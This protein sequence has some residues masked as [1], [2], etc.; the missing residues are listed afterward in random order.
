MKTFARLKASD[1][2]GGV[3]LLVLLAILCGIVMYQPSTVQEHY[4][5]PL[6][7]HDLNPGFQKAIIKTRC[8][9]IPYTWETIMEIKRNGGRALEELKELIQ[10][11]TSDINPELIVAPIRI[12]MGIESTEACLDFHDEPE[13]ESDPFE[14][15]LV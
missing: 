8:Y 1:V 4:M 3:I 12:T 13:Q 7:I 14:T 5:K 15:R 9:N 6:S 10:E 2:T 11:Q